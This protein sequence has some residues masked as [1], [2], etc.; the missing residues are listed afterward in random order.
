MFSWLYF[1]WCVEMAASYSVMNLSSYPECSEMLQIGSV[2]TF[3]SLGYISHHC[4]GAQP[5]WEMGHLGV[6]LVQRVRT[7]SRLD[8]LP[9]TNHESLDG[10]DRLSPC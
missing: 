3:T 1:G 5:A 8:A 4:R 7:L 6:G 2:T 9:V 10:I